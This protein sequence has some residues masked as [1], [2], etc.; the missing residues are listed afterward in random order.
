M[1]LTAF[2]AS[3]QIRDADLLSQTLVPQ[4]ALAASSI[5]RQ[6]QDPEFSKFLGRLD[7]TKHPTLDAL[8]EVVL[9]E[10]LESQ[11]V[12]FVE[13]LLKT[14]KP[15]F[16]ER[17]PGPWKDSNGADSR[18]PLHIAIISGSSSMVQLLLQHGADPHEGGQGMSDLLCIAMLN[19]KQE[20][21][22]LLLQAYKED[23]TLAFRTALKWKPR[24]V[25]EMF[26]MEMLNFTS[27]SAIFKAEML[28]AAVTSGWASSAQG[29]LRNGTN[30]NV[31]NTYGNTPLLVATRPGQKRLQAASLL[32]TSGAKI[33]SHID[34]Q[35]R[36]TPTA[37]QLA[38]YWNN[39][40]LAALLMDLGAD[41]NAEG[42]D[43]EWQSGFELQQIGEERLWKQNALSLAVKFAEPC[44]VQMLLQKGAQIGDTVLASAVRNSCLDNIQLL[45]EYGARYSN[46]ILLVAASTWTL[47]VI[48]HCLDL[49]LDVNYVQDGMNAFSAAASRLEDDL[50]DDVAGFK[51]ICDLLLDFGAD[52]NLPNV[53]PTAL[54][55]SIK[56]G[57][58]DV[59]DFLLSRGAHCG[60]AS[61]V[62]TAIVS[63]DCVLL[64]KILAA[65]S[66]HQGF[67]LCYTTSCLGHPAFFEAVSHSSRLNGGC[68][69]VEIFVETGI[70]LV[71]PCASMALKLLCSQED[72]NMSLIKRLL[73]AG[74]QIDLPDLGEDP[75]CWK[76]SFSEERL[77]PLQLLAERGD[78]EAVRLLLEFGANTNLFGQNVLHI[79]R[80]RYTTL[81]SILC[82]SVTCGQLSTIRLLLDAGADVNSPA[83]GDFGHTALQTAAQLG[84]M[85]TL[86]ELVRVG[87]D[88][89]AG[90][91]EFGGVTAL[92][93]AAIGGFTGIAVR[94][95]E[96]GAD[97]NAAAA[98][99]EGRTALEGASEHGRIDMVQFLLTAGADVQSPDFGAIQHENA[100]N[101]ARKWGYN[102][103]ARLLK[104]HWESL[105]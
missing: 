66:T 21:V 53:S 9:K 5:F 74:I 91:A 71:N 17:L 3:N 29:L 40:E 73:E 79:G 93:A 38:A 92:Q 42:C 75:P 30:V 10:A 22:R 78:D 83:R 84:Q 26:W 82:S 69:M 51:E 59:V 27:D 98:E 77:H 63:G 90:P 2:L 43:E 102:A 33:E 52:I 34:R 64:K 86:E 47:D 81:R 16:D 20:I 65:A 39:T 18:T 60:C 41:I 61:S 11:N 4:N 49:R 25:N 72:L 95:V 1:M 105:G 62:Q 97:V 6:L 44:L 12:D 104:R 103:V 68:K 13:T 28:F 48:R 89:N 45:L 46:H 57:R 32:I 31:Q 55:L 87:A 15:W 101:F 14:T 94:L 24:C 56:T 36:R 54:E 96:L 100:V 99:K 80:S 19:G 7:I 23:P 35:G 37:L 8:L 50:V 67:H 85:N 76:Q 70:N 58:A 88:V